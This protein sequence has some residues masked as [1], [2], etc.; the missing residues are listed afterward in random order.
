LARKRG[1]GGI[2][3]THQFDISQKN[4]LDN[5]ERRRTLPPE[6]T[7]KKLGLKTGEIMADIGCGIGYFTF[8]AGRI[9]GPGGMVY[10]MDITDEMLQQVEVGKKHNKLTNI[11]TV[12][13]AEYDLKLES[14]SVSFAFICNVLHEIEDLGPFIGEIK[15]IL[16]DKGRLVVIEW[17]KQVLQRISGPP[18]EHRLDKEKLMS[19]LMEYGFKRID[20]Q[21]IGDQYYSM[22]MEKG[23]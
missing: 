2:K 1:N 8:P 9:V 21:H 6:E 22:I 18:L 5:P 16:K 17:E 11:E 13:T 3:V 4:K 15:R 7:L 10:A 12:K 19:R 23:K 20:C 14:G